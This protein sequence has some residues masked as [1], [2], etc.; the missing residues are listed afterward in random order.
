MAILLNHA[1]EFKSSMRYLLLWLHSNSVLFAKCLFY[2]Y[3]VFILY[4]LRCNGVFKRTKCF[5][6]LNI[7]LN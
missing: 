5:K 4:I 2:I 6:M 1:I 7:G 3:E